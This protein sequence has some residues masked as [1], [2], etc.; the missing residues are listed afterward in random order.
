[1]SSWVRRHLLLTG[2][3]A[4]IAAAMLV[5]GVVVVAVRPSAPPPRYTRL[6]PACATVTRTSLGKFL[7]GAT[8]TPQAL[9]TSGGRSTVACKWSSANGAVDRSLTAR[10]TLFRPGS[11]RDARLSY[12]QFL[13]G[14]RCRCQGITPVEQPVAG[15]GDQAAEVFVAARPGAYIMT[16]P[17]VAFPGANLL[18]Q[19]GNALLTLNLETTSSASG[20]PLDSPPGA[21][22]VDGMGGL[23]R[24]MLAALNGPTLVSPSTPV[25]AVPHYPATR[26]PCR[27][28]SAATLARYAP[29]ARVSPQPPV[30]SSA[31]SPPM[32]SCVWDSNGGLIVLSLFLYHD[33]VNAQ[34]VFEASEG[35]GM[36]GNGATVTGS[37]WVPD[38]GEGAAA[39]FTARDVELHVWSGNAELDYQYSAHGQAISRAVLLAG[40][41]AMARDGL[42]GLRLA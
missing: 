41:I 22:R 11:V 32:T 10:I 37:Q 28:V 27:L 40:A 23:A 19:S 34:Q 8:G 15:L 17:A 3:S 39:T 6:P 26:D 14:L 35:F 42:A 1:M 30:G 20:N 21:D 36:S 29:E 13:S 16:A 2:V 24:D 25:A 7:P 4:G 12:R 18:V 38:V 33:A 5:A 31:G 9:E